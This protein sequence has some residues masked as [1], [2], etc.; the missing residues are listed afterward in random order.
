MYRKQFAQKRVPNHKIGY[1]IT[2]EGRV[3]NHKIEYKIFILVATPF[4]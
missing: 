1:Q 3:S 4:A 2:K